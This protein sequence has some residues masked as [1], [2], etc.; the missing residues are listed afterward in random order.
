MLLK[1]IEILG[2]VLKD[3]YARILRSK[4]RELI[5]ELFNGPLRALRSF[6]NICE[7]NPDAL[8]TE[9]ELAIK[10]SGKIPNDEERKSIAKKVVA[11]I[12][13]VVTFNFVLR[14]ARGANSDN[15]REDVLNV[16]EENGSLAF[17]VIDMFIDLDSPKDI[18]RRKLEVLLGN[19]AKEPVAMRIIEMMVINRLYMFKT[20]ERD[21]QW[22]REKLKI[23]MR[24]QHSISYQ[25]NEQRVNK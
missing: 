7:E 20:K 17:K 24:L 6:Y 11:S 16:V 5:E 4:K 25:T 12:L 8:V 3:Q 21:M 9:I 13:Q 23:N 15:L 10:R 14:A 2:Q 1:T 18:P 22:I 19:A